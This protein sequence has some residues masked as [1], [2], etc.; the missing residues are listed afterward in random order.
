MTVYIFIGIW[1]E[2]RDLT[3][4]FGARYEQ[5]KRTTSKIIPFPKSNS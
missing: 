3:N 4:Q 1:H 2:E 5:Y